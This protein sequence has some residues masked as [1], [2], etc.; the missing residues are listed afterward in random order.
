MYR[1]PSTSDSYLNDLCDQL[2]SIISSHPSS[3]VWIAG[4]R[5]L[6]DIVWSDYSVKG[7]AYPLI[8]NNIFLSFLDTNGLSQ[9]VN[10]P[11][12]GTDVLDIFLTN[13]PSLIE[14]LNIIARW[15][16]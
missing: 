10:T 14:T 15:N 4:D 13:R 7:N 1:P 5:N 6:P 12:R 11:T 8:I 16:Q 9:V 2:T 3:L